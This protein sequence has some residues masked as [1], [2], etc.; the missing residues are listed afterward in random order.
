MYFACCEK[1]C[2]F[3]CVSHSFTDF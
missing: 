3:Q 2:V 1:S